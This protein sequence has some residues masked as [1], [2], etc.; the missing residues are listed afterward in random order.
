MVSGEVAPRHKSSHA[1]LSL[2][3]TVDRVGGTMGR[4]ILEFEGRW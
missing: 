1:D 2:S 3:R 4:L